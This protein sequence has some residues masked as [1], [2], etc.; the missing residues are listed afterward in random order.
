MLQ[1]GSLQQESISVNLIFDYSH[2][3]VTLIYA[4]SV[5]FKSGILLKF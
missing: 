1:Y 4:I 2:W 5:Q 3:F